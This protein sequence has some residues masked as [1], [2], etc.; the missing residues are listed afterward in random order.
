MPVVPADIAGLLAS[1]RNGTLATLRRDGRPQLSVVTYAWYPDDRA[2]GEAGEGREI[3]RISTVEGRAKVANL[4]RDPRASFLV[5]GGSGWSYAVVD[6][7]VELSPVAASHDDETVEELITVY[8][9][10]AG[11]HPD[12]ADYRRA[13]VDDHRLVARLVV[14]HAY[15]LVRS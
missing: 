8:R 5:S 3:V 6:G 14:E 11:E 10:A 15:G 7:T 9:D 1:R 12:W 13:M 2:H 4:R